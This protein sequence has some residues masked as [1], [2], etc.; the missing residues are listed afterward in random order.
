MNFRVEERSRKQGKSQAGLF[1]IGMFI[2]QNRELS[3]G[4]ADV[5]GLYKRIKDVYPDAKLSKHKGYVLVE[6]KE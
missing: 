2:A 4:T 5:E 3:I 1:L 6:K